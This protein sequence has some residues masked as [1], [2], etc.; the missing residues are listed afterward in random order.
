M[1]TQAPQFASSF[2]TIIFEHREATP[3]VE[4]I[5]LQSGP[6]PTITRALKHP[7]YFSMVVQLSLLSWVHEKTSLARTIKQILEK[8]QEGAPA[9]S[10]VQVVPSQ[11]GLVGVIR[12]CEEQTASYECCINSRFRLCAGPHCLRRFATLVS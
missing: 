1:I 9:G 3:L 7:P 12:A 5:F 2:K 8:R 10:G 11:D 4:G 6:G